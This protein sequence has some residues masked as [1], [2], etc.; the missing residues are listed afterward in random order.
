MKTAIRPASVVALLLVGV[1][2]A[3]CGA[4]GPV[5]GGYG[6][7]GSLQPTSTTNAASTTPGSGTTKTKQAA[8]I[9]QT[10]EAN[11]GRQ[12]HSHSI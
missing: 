11:S 2:M 8:V 1:L 12:A 3:G 5:G 10:S 9:P 7:G 4:S 6:Y